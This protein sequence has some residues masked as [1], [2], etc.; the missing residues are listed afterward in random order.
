METEEEN[1]RINLMKNLL[2]KWEPEEKNQKTDDNLPL[3]DREYSGDVLLF[4]GKYI[5]N[6]LLINREQSANL[7]LINEN[8]QNWK[9]M[10]NMHLSQ[11]SQNW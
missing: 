7:L 2:I 9:M 6:V 1:L 11:S 10:L 8:L 3:I 5:G 4:D